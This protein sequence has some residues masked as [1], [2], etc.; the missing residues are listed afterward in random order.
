MGRHA[1]ACPNVAA[2]LKQSLVGKAEV[3]VSADD[4]VIEEADPDDLSG[5]DVPVCDRPVFRTR[6]ETAGGMVQNSAL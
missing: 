1:R 4:D 6:G 2:I 3:T 5:F